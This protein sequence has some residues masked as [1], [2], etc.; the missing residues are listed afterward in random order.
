MAKKKSNEAL[1]AQLRQ[2]KHLP[3]DANIKITQEDEYDIFFEYDGMVMRVEKSALPVF[4]E[5]TEPEP[6]TTIM[7][8]PK[9]D[10]A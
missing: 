10:K 8:E 6:E 2:I 7:D 3:S 1:L 9:P 5:Y 4:P